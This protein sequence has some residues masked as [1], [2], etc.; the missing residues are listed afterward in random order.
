[1]AVCAWVAAK[2]EGLRS[3][4]PC[5]PPKLPCMP[6]ACQLAIAPQVKWKQ[7]AQFLACGHAKARLT[8]LATPAAPAAAAVSAS[9]SSW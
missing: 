9:A 4:P 6:S 2:M 1:M 3:V 5:R 8:A 7:P